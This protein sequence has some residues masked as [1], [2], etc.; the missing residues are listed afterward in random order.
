MLA[1]ASI[2]CLLE[3]CSSERSPPLRSRKLTPMGG[4]LFYCGEWGAEPDQH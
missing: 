4:V 3:P 2:S 1:K